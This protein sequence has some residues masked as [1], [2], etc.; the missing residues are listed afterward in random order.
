MNVINGRKKKS[1]TKRFS[2]ENDITSSK[3]P[4]ELQGLTQVEKMLIARAFPVIQIYTKP[5]SGQKA[6]KGYALTLPHDVQTIANVLPSDIPAIVFKAY[7]TTRSV[8]FVLMMTYNKKK[9]FF[10]RT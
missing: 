10:I 2:I 4:L 8:C 1:L 5:K 7:N 9:S 3:V 6:C